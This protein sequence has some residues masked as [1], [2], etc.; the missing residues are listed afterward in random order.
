[1]ARVEAKTMTDAV[2]HVEDLSLTFAEVY[3]QYF[4]FVWRNARSLGI[5]SAALDDVV[6]EIFVVVHRRRSDFEGRSSLRTWLSGI[7]LN[8]VRHHRRSQS[9]KSPHELSR[10]A[11]EDPDLLP[12][13]GRDPYENAS[14]AEGTRLVQRLL[15]LL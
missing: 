9:R 7:V 11:A 2:P 14:F 6:Q 5:H 4:A 8:V 1:M 12:A 3:R 13:F 10:E 15:D